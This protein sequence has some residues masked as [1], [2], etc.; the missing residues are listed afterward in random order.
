[1]LRRYAVSADIARFFRSLGAIFRITH[2]SQSTSAEF[3][4]NSSIALH[5]TFLL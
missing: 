3:I 1:M 2:Q 5:L 4:N